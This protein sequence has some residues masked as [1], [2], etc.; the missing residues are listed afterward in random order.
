VQSPQ[1]PV[2]VGKVRIEHALRHPGWI[3]ASCLP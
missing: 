2:D 3:E 1:P